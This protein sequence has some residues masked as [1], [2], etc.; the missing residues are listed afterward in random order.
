MIDY[1]TVLELVLTS[2]YYTYR[3]TGLFNR[4]VAELNTTL[5]FVPAACGGGDKFQKIMSFYNKT[6][7]RP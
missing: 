2:Y 6:N 5:K 3:V 7:K 1:Y 4:L